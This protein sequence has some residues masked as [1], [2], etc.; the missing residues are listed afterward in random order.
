MKFCG[1]SG[2]QIGVKIPSVQEDLV[3]DSL[4]KIDDDEYKSPPGFLWILVRRPT[5]VLFLHVNI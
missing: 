1:E 5:T 4:K 3:H 2:R